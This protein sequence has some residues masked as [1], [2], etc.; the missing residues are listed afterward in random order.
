VAAID[1]A[2]QKT[3]HEDDN[4]VIS[5]AAWLLSKQLAQLAPRQ[6][7]AIETD[8]SQTATTWELEL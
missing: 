6:P 2:R 1:L 8:N 3:H 7:V 4:R 5:S